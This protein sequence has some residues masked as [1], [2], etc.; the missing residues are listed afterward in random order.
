MKKIV[1]AALL[2][3]LHTA[4]H[5][6]TIEGRVVGVSDGDTLTVLDAQKKQHKIRLGEIDAPESGQ[7]F[8]DRSKEALALLC[9]RTD[10][11]VR[12]TDTDRYGRTVGRV[13]CN[14][15]DANAAQVRAG[16]AWVYDQHVIDR[17]LYRLQ[18]EAKTEKRGLWADKNPM[19]PW[20]WRQRQR[21]AGSPPTTT[22]RT[23]TGT[24]GQSQATSS[25][26]VRGNKRSMIYH[27]P[28]CEHYNAIS[29]R[30]VVVFKT[31]SDASAAGY[32][33]AGNC[34]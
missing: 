31:E 33:K 14:K 8:G 3:A 30:N 22:S 34:R 17:G 6:Q 25:V 11:H 15:R 5:A 19:A 29:P 1:I 21:T 12:V 27:V 20:D 13:T 18:D 26:E 23:T 32:R 4:A 16:L 24:T 2:L 10:A 7:A 28:G 9:L